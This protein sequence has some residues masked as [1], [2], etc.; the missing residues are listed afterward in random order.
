MPIK[1]PLYQKHIELGGKVVDFAGFLLP[2]QYSGIIAEVNAVRN[3]AGIFDVSHMGQLMLSGEGAQKTLQYVLTNDFSDMKTGAARYSPMCRE[4]GG[5]VDDLLVYKIDPEKFM[6]VVNAANIQK[7]FEWLKAHLLPGCEMENHS[8]NYALLAVQ[9]PKSRDIMQKLT[10]TLPE[11]YYFFIEDAKINGFNCLIS[12]TGYTGE[13]GYEIYCEPEHAGKLFD[14]ILNAGK[15]FGLIPCGLGA[16]DVLRQEAA[17]PLYGHEISEN[18]TPKD[19][20]LGYFIKLNKPD[21]IGKENL[22]TEKYKRI[23]LE[24]TDRGIVREGAKVFSQEEEIGF[25]SSG[26]FSPTLKKSIAIAYIPFGFED[27]SNLS[28]DVR[29]KMLKCKQ[30]PLPFYKKREV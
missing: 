15:E 16:R 14:I 20:G 8:E 23:G 29:G 7:D 27:L 12:Q 18:L 25:I 17:M 4:S 5:T 10:D 3:N 24:I 28:V 1:T 26:T 9:G 13:L 21:F 19:A 30:V 6:I 22:Q 2:I 11:K